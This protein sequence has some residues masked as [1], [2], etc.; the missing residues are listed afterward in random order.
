MS[1][2]AKILTAVAL[3]VMMALSTAAWAGAKSSYSIVINLS[4]STGTA[5]GAVGSARNSADSIQYIGCAVY[6]SV[7]SD[8][9]G[10]PYYKEFVS[11]SARDVNNLTVSCSSAD[12]VLVQVAHAMTSD[13]H[14]TF[15]WDDS[16]ACTSLR[17]RTDS[18]YAPKSP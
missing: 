14:L 13:A 17:T 10:N 16:G 2:Y 15:S 18:R 3:T 5:M 8:E 4:G 11:C 1:Q 12:P 7:A 9:L 6:T